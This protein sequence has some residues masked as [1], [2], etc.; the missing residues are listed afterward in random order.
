MIALSNW[1]TAELHP[2]IAQL[3]IAQVTNVQKRDER[4]SLPILCDVRSVASSG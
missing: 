3:D 2:W 4:L 1:E